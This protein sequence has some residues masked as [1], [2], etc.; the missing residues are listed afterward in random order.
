MGKK[1]RKE[2]IKLRNSYINNMH[3]SSN[4]YDVLVF[5]VSMI[6]M[7]LSI[8]YSENVIL[9]ILPALNILLLLISFLLS[10]EAHTMTIKKLDLE[11]T[12]SPLPQSLDKDI[13]NINKAIGTI[14]SVNLAFLL[15]SFVL[16]ALQY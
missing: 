16:F 7:W 8:L 2:F 11:Y 10:E 15:I 12:E 3:K 1:Q 14:Q 13:G 9:F 6:M 4:M 5:V